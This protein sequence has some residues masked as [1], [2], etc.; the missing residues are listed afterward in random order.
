MAVIL[1]DWR[2]RQ[3]EGLGVRPSTFGHDPDRFRLYGKTIG[4]PTNRDGKYVYAS[5]PIEFNEKARVVRT[6][7]GSIYTLGKC[8][9]LN[10]EE[11]FRFIRR[12]VIRNKN[13]TPPPAIQPTTSSTRLEPTPPHTPTTPA[14]APTNTDHTVIS[15]GDIDLLVERE[16]EVNELMAADPVPSE[17]VEPGRMVFE[18]ADDDVERVEHIDD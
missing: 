2:Y 3:L 10:E 4:H 11:Q 7:S 18:V 12:D 1:E 15:L 17:E 5:S 9:V 6:I 14:R 8:G 16:M 13:A